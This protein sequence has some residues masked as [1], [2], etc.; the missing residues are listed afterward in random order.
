MLFHPFCTTFFPTAFGATHIG[1]IKEDGGNDYFV[2]STDR[3]HQLN[4]SHRF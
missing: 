1:R 2:N 4:A 3:Y